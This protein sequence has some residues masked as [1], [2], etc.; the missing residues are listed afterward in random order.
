M[1]GADADSEAEGDADASPDVT[2]DG[3]GEASNGEAAGMDAVGNEAFETMPQTHQKARPPFS[4]PCPPLCEKGT[5]RFRAVYGFKPV[6]AS[7]L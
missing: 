1:A 4:H 3:D 6:M 2:G 5:V 7:M